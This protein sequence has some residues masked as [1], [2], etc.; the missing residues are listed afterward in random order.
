MPPTN[1]FSGPI[2][3]FH[4]LAL[5]EKATPAGYAALI[6]AYRLQV[7]LPRTL[8]ATSEHHR[9][10]NEEGWRILTPRHTPAPDLEAH[11]TFALKNEGLD[12]AVL[13]R[14]F[15]V[16]TPAEIE[17]IVR[18]KPT[19]GY[20]RR[21]WFLYEWLLDR[22]LDLPDTRTGNYEPV[23]D[24]QQQW[25]I[26]GEN[27]PRHR[28]RNNLP[29]TPAFCPLVFR[30]ETTEAFA[31]MYLAQRAQKEVAAVARVSR[32]KENALR[33][34][35]SGAGGKPSPRLDDGPSMWK[36]S[37]GCRPSSSATP[38]SSSLDS[39]K[40][41]ALSASMIATRACPSPPISAPGR[42]ICRL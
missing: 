13:R 7:P 15:A 21:L 5:P 34:I 32:L 20:A 6:D 33:R 42:T 25:A 18:A 17:A 12:L 22:R 4:G 10:R 27:S 19:G 39:G 35:G 36:N 30:T 41:V 28:V 16:V 24:P 37:C 11:L 14:L 3:N 9:T 2:T 40:K 1:Q 29:G 26:P 38:A 8:F 23:V 31:A